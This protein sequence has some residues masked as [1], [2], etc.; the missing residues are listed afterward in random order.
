MIVGFTGTSRGMNELQKAL[1]VGVIARLCPETFHHGDCV[2]ADADAHALIRLHA[3]RCRII[4]HPPD[5]ATRRAFCEGDEMRDAK[6]YLERN[7]AIVACCEEL[8]AVPKGRAEELRSGTW[9][10]VRAARRSGKRIH[11]VWP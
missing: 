3:P 8:V 10:T 2:G 7:R 9:M 11:M 5:N 1:F 4:I 6:P